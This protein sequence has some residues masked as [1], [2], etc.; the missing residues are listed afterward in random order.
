MIVNLFS[1]HNSLILIMLYVYKMPFL[2]TP[3]S[4][5]HPASCNKP[6]K[7][8][9][10]KQL[11]LRVSWGKGLK[12]ILGRGMKLNIYKFP[13]FLASYAVNNPTPSIKNFVFFI[14]LLFPR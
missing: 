5:I 11:N 9:A 8:A 7:G 10:R 3:W 4:F 14:R 2:T 6:C 12:N 1:K 13:R